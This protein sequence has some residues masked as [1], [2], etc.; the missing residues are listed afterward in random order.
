[1]TGSRTLALSGW[2]ELK[3]LGG[4]R[5]KAGME[6]SVLPWPVPP[7]LKSILN[8][9]S[10]INMKKVLSRAPEDRTKSGENI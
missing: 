3:S 5:A 2:S 8:P 7:K 4:S 10:P 9:W 6:A 1:M